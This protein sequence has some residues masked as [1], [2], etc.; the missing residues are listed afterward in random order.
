M[1]HTF[2]YWCKETE[3]LYLLTNKVLYINTKVN[4]YKPADT[5][6]TLHINIEKISV[7]GNKDTN[8]EKNII[9]NFSFFM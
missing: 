2:I 9:N 5:D 8:I 1:T 4:V 7:T 3:T 6:L